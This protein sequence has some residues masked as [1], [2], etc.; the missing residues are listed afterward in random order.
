MIAVTVWGIVPKNH[1]SVS[2]LFANRSAVLREILFSY[3]SGLMEE[4]APSGEYIPKSEVITRGLSVH[5][6]WT[7]EVPDD[8][9][10]KIVF[11]NLAFNGYN[12]DKCVH[13]GNNALPRTA[14]WLMSN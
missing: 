6:Y 3:I 10:V 1:I 7:I 4:I 14:K 11:K 8:S 9:F 2:P 13:E 12:E 5:C